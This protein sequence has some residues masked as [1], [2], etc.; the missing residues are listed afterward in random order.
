[1]VVE[2]VFSDVVADVAVVSVCAFEVDG[3]SSANCRGLIRR[4]KGGGLRLLD[5]S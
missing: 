3:C 4:L 5:G 1:M 2:D